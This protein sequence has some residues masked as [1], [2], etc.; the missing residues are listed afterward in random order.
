[1]QTPAQGAMVEK[2]RLV[3][4]D[5]AGLEVGV[6]SS[7]LSGSGFDVQQ[8]GTGKVVLRQTPSPGARA[9]PGA[10]VKIST[11][12]SEIAPPNG[13]AMVPDVCKMSIRRAINR[14][15]IDK[16]DVGITG[17]GIVVEQTPLPGR[18]VKVGTRVSLRCEPRNMGLVGHG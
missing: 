13:F 18:Q 12:E 11:S 8:F 10:A 1:M 6:A 4:P 16:F 7:M 5:V 3:V 17:S 15:T 9:L 14:L 2:Q